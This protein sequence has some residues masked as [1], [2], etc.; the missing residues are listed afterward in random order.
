MAKYVITHAKII[1]PQAILLNRDLF[2]EDG[3]IVGI[4]RAEKGKRFFAI[5]ARQNFLSPGFIDLHIHGEIKDISENEARGGTT[6]FLANLHPAS[7]QE[8]I[9]QIAGIKEEKTQLLGARLLG[10]RLEGPYLNPAFA[11]ALP[12]EKLRIPSLSEAKEI[13]RQAGGILKMVVLAPELPQAITV[14]KFLKNKGVI[15]SLGHSAASFAEALRAFRAGITHATH[16]FN[17]LAPFDHKEPGAIA[18]ILTDARVW[19]EVICDG[20][21]VHPAVLRI[22]LCAKTSDKVTLITD[23]TRSQRWPKKIRVGDIFRLKD[24]TL[25]GSALTMMKAVKNAVRFMGVSLPEAVKMASLNPAKIL[26]RGKITGSIEEGKKADLVIFD[27]NFQV[28]M[29]MVEGKI[30]YSRGI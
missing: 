15:A 12:K 13:L 9:Q 14:I 20:I 18:A 17:R 30:V 3:K 22:L 23:S 19:A 24:G 25:Y 4:R 2:I 27:R 28:K 10:V 7:P 21:H 5:D 26:G 1:S 16:V 11:G 6:G 8:I 29:T